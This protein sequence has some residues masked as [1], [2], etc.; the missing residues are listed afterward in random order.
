MDI[1]DTRM[2]V[3]WQRA[4]ALPRRAA[5]SYLIDGKGITFSVQPCRYVVC[6]T[7]SQKPIYC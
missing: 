1:L 3:L 6:R 5:D 7:D 2:S 4:G